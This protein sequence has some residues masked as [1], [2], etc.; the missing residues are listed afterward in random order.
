MKTAIV[1]SVQKSKQ[2]TSLSNFRPIPVLP[3]VAKI[4]EQLV[5]DMV[6]GHLLSYDL[7][8]TKQ[9]GFCPVHSTQMFY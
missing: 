9:S 5:F 8:S 7:L 2:N 3:V 1:T 6:V 4:L